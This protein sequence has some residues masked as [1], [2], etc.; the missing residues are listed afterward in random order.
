MN[1]QNNQEA[2]NIARIF[3]SAMSIFSEKEKIR[4]CHII[5]SL[6]NYAVTGAALTLA[7]LLS[8]RGNRC[9][10]LKYLSCL[11][12]SALECFIECPVLPLTKCSPVYHD[13][14]SG[15]RSR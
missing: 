1:I 5:T 14:S 7:L 9:L 11:L 3:F 13:L 6:D 12:L 8:P 2:R 15:W 4:A 10:N